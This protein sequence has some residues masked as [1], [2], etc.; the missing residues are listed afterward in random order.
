M[1]VTICTCNQPVSVPSSTVSIEEEKPTD[2]LK[3]ISTEK[4]SFSNSPSPQS[5]KVSS[6]SVKKFN[7]TEEIVHLRK[8]KRT[9]SSKSLG[10]Q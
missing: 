1:G 10:S 8:K 9:K 3:K 2:K 6:N 5:N 7:P 4:T